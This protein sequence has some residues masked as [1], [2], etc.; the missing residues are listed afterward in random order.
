[1]LKV[2]ISGYVRD[3]ELLLDNQIIPSSIHGIILGYYYTKTF[4]CY[5][6]KSI[7]KPWYIADIHSDSH[8]AWNSNTVPL[9]SSID[10]IESTGFTKVCMAHDMTRSLATNITNQLHDMWMNDTRHI[11]AMF[12][13]GGYHK[14]MS[15]QCS[16]IL[17]DANLSSNTNEIRSCHYRLPD[18]P[19]ATWGNA[20]IYSHTHGL[21]SVCGQSTGKDVYSLNISDGENEIKWIKLTDQMLHPHYY[22]SVCVISDGS[23]E[24]LFVAAGHQSKNVIAKKMDR[25]IELYDFNNDTWT[26]LADCIIR[27]SI[28]GLFYDYIQ[29]IVYL[30]GS[31]LSGINNRGSKTVEYYDI[32]KN[33]WRLLPAT[34]FNH[35][36]N[37][38][39]WKEQNSSLLYIASITSNGMEYIDLRAKPTSW[40]VECGHADG[41]FKPILKP[42][43]ETRFGM[44]FNDP[45][46]GSWLLPLQMQV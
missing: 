22:P 23:T 36:W 29:Q 25:K 20:T 33:V 43:L 6:S 5:L 28:C 38:L 16:A 3:I 26:Q 37:P 42:K 32:R 19:I 21:L 31:Q 18:L 39:I 45:S 9:R 17:F 24:K 11:C 2:L 34:N 41:K 1:M 12:R 30:G 35:E 7:Q 13:C 10:N 14:G 40:I 46:Q 27:R 4:I 44:T 15:K 8:Q